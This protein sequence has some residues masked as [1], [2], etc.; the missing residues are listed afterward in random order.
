MYFYLDI[1]SRY[2]AHIIYLSTYTWL[3]LALGS[4]PLPREL[5]M[6]DRGATSQLGYFMD[7]LQPLAER[8]GLR[9]TDRVVTTYRLPQLTME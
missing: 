4:Q 9:W 6:T 2:A 8:G 3:S 5:H 7:L 1:L